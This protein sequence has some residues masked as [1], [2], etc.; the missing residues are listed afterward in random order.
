MGDGHAR[1]WWLAVANGAPAR[2]WP[3][4]SLDPHGHK[5]MTV[6]QRKKGAGRNNRIE[7]ALGPVGNPFAPVLQAEIVVRHSQASEETSRFRELFANDNL[8]H[9][10]FSSFVWRGR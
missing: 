3:P 6:G 9:Q 2:V 10:R 5:L 8:P 4:A 7:Q 1:L